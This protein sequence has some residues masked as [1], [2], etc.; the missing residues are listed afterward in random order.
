M[1][2]PS[3]TAAASSKLMS[4]GL[5]QR[6]IFSHADEPRVRAHPHAEDAVAD[7]ELGD[8]CADCLDLVGE[9][10]AED[11]PLRSAEAGE[12]AREERL[13]CASAGPTRRFV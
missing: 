2:A 6:T 10:G 9:L 7:I 8:G 1:I 3:H 12:E 4:A 11:P 5:C 13:G